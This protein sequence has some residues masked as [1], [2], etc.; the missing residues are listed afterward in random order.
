M[1]P[2]PEPARLGTLNLTEGRHMDRMY[3]RT[4]KRYY[5]TERTAFYRT[6]FQESGAEKMERPAP[7]KKDR[8]YDFRPYPAEMNGENKRYY[9]SGRARRPVTWM[10]DFTFDESG[11]VTGV[12]YTP[13][14]TEEGD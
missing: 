12:S 1:T 8:R 3:R 9:G 14:P 6:H 11:K 10:A 13:V 7:Q 2:P 4:P 5:I